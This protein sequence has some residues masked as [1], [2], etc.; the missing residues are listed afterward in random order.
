MDREASLQEARESLRRLALLGLVRGIS[1][2][3]LIYSLLQVRKRVARLRTEAGEGT[4]FKSDDLVT[5]DHD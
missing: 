5:S 2:V 4:C 3:L 1:D